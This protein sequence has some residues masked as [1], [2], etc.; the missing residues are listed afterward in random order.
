VTDREH[1]VASGVVSTGS[2]VGAVVGLAILVL[3][4]NAGTE[5]L[6]GEGL[7]AAT[8]D[9]I[10]TA[11]FAIAGGIVVTLLLAIGLRAAPNIR[12]AVSTTR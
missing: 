12:H 10:R 3:F 4:A 2:G 8:A 5:G 1:G 7:R 11:M 9:G 6:V